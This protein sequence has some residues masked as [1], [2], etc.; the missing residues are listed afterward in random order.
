[1]GQVLSRQGRIPAQLITVA[2]GPHANRRFAE[3]CLL[4]HR[5]RHDS[6]LPGRHA[7]LVRV[8]CDRGRCRILYLAAGQWISRRA[9]RGAYPSQQI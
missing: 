3:T 8:S 9:F 6:T 5:A 4:V 1:M 7:A 2:T